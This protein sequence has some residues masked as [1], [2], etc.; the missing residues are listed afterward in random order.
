MTG[1]FCLVVPFWYYSYKCFIWNTE[2]Q[3][4]GY[5]FISIEDFKYTLYGAIFYFCQDKLVHF[6][7]FERMRDHWC[8]QQK[9]PE[10]TRRFA[11]KA[12]ML[13]AKNLFFYPSTIWGYMVLKDTVWTPWWMGGQHPE[14]DVWK[15]FNADFIEFP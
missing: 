13:I 15:I 14:A 9:T 11:Q 12:T 6:L 5:G 1:I 8:K 4:E 3:P 7:F 10:L 2:N